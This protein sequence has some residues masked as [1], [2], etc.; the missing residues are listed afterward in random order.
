MKKILNTMQVESLF[1]KLSDNKVKRRKMKVVFKKVG[2]K[3]NNE[4]ERRK[5][6]MNIV[7]LVILKLCIKFLF[8]NARGMFLGGTMIEI[9]GGVRKYNW[10]VEVKK[11]LEVSLERQSKNAGGCIYLMLVNFLNMLLFLKFDACVLVMLCN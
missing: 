11:A 4:E 6:K 2:E 1:G 9:W 3:T 5:K 10:A 7:R 8:P